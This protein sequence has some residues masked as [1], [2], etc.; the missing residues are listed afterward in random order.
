MMAYPIVCGRVP[1]ITAYDLL[2]ILED[3]LRASNVERSSSD[4]PVGAAPPVASTAAIS[5]GT[6]AG[7]LM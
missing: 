6:I 3:A 2:P 7:R 1:I 4:S 5:G